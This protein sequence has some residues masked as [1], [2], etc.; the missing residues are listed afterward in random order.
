M[1]GTG[2]AD[3]AFTPAFTQQENPREAPGFFPLISWSRFPLD[4]PAK[5]SFPD[6]PVFPVPVP[7]DFSVTVLPPWFPCSSSSLGLFQLHPRSSCACAELW[8]GFA[9]GFS[10]GR[11]ISRSQAGADAIQALLALPAVTQDLLGS[12]AGLIPGAILGWDH[13]MNCPI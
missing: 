2:L 5:L 9:A 10:Q 8:G 12:G 4:F 1:P 3:P 11:T 7:L 13:G 6:F